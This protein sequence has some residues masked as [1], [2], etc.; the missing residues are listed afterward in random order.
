MGQ[1]V[2]MES[3]VYIINWH[4]TLW[5][6]RFHDSLLVTTALFLKREIICRS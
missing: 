6:L 1:Q 4:P 2:A 3:E 5:K